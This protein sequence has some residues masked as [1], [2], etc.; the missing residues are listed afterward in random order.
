MIAVRIIVTFGVREASREP[1]GVLEMSP[2]V[3]GDT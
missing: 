1:A 3:G 2:I